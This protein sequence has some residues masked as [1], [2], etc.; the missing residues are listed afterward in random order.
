MIEWSRRFDHMQQHTGQHVLSAAFDRLLHVRTVS[1][2]MGDASSTIDLAREVTPAEL[3]AAE[4]EANRVVWE[5]RPVAIR[6][7]TPAEAAALPLRKEPV[8]E[9]T[10]RLIDVEGFD[11]SAC[12]GTHVLRTGAIGIIAVAS[13]E[14]FKGGSR[15]EFVCGGRALRRFHVLRD[16]AAIAGR[17]LSVGP[18]ELAA[19]IERLQADGRDLRRATTA[20]QSELARFRADEL[21]ASAEPLTRRAAAAPAPPLKFV[22]RA[23]DADASALKPLAAAVAV[24]AGFLVALM[25]TSQPAVVVIARSPDVSIAANA[26]VAAVIARFGGKGGGRPELAQAGGVTALPADLFALVRTL[27]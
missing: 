25:S 27:V 8:R 22:A 12:G 13:V 1:F 14:R 10:L 24:N 15:V 16:A 18:D 23:L 3:A 7:A 11:L 26:L 17:L 4:E 5:D 9:G 19:S 6:F 21:A 20:L 2:H